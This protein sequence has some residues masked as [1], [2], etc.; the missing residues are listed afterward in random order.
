MTV[1]VTS[2]ASSSVYVTLAP[3]RWLAVAR[4]LGPRGAAENEAGEIAIA[5]TVA[6][7]DPGPGPG[8]GV[9]AGAGI[10]TGPAGGVQVSTIPGAA[11]GAARARLPSSTSPPGQIAKPTEKAMPATMQ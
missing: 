11:P 3:E 5:L 2:A 6:G 7:P 8:V 10:G 4:A 9:G 1:K